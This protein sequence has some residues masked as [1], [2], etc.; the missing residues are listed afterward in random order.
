MERRN[1]TGGSVLTSAN[2]KKGKGLYIRYTSHSW[3]TSERYWVNLMA[4]LKVW[5]SEVWVV[6]IYLAKF[7][8][9]ANFPIG[10]SR[11]ITRNCAYTHISCVELY[12]GVSLRAHNKTPNIAF[13]LPNFGP[14]FQNMRDL[15]FSDHM[16]CERNMTCS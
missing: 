14:R 10:K 6:L 1:C 13:F 12:I 5:S 2:R 9:L 4:Q 16:D 7:I 11:I 15:M 8:K 3:T